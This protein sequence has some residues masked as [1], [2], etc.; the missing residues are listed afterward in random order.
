MPEYSPRLPDEDLD[1]WE[2]RQ[3]PEARVEKA[4]ASRHLIHEAICASLDYTSEDFNDEDGNS[5]TLEEILDTYIKVSMS[6]E[7]YLTG[8]VQI[9]LWPTEVE[10][11]AATLMKNK[12]EETIESLREVHET[13]RKERHV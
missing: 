10:A 12:L 9:A 8:I 13:L 2:Y 5:R 6:D 1:E 4:L 3:T 7:Q 11:L